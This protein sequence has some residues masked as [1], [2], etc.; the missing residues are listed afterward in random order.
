LSHAAAAIISPP[1][2]RYIANQQRKLQPIAVPLSVSARSE[3]AGYFNP[4]DLNRVRIV[5][6]D[7][8]PINE[9][10][11]AGIIRR[12]GLD[13]P[14]VALTAAITFDSVIASREP[15]NSS[16]LFHELVHVVQY[17]LLGV[18][19]FAR[20]YVHGFLAGGS[21]HDIPLECCAFKLEGRFV[22]GEQVFDVEAEV[23]SRMKA[24]RF[25]H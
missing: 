25:W 15:M 23:A 8:L 24:S 6:A 21:Y 17:R 14:S 7:P 9:P 19:A 20:L 13:F 1:I 12:L 18:D 10:P 16:L 3:M 2:S 11:F 5:V 4:A 22:K